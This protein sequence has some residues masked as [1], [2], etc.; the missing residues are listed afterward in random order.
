MSQT[1]RA[2]RLSRKA[3]LIGGQKL[4]L[5]LLCELYRSH[6]GDGEDIADFEILGAI[7]EKVGIMSK[8]KVSI[9]Y[10]T[11]SHALTT[12]LQGYRVPEIR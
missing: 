8:E 10:R 11:D 2:H 1:T 5:P 12:I 6:L 3:F 4:Q 9:D 7:S